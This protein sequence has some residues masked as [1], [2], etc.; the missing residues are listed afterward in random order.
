MKAL[1]LT[2]GNSPIHINHDVWFNATDMAN[3]FGKRPI[4]WLKQKETKEYIRLLCEDY[5]VRENHFL[6][7]QKGKGKN[8]TWF[9]HKLAIRFAQ[10]LDTRF[11]IWCDKQIYELLTGNWQKERD[12]SKAYYRMMTDTLQQSRIDQGKETKTHHYINEAKLI[13]YALTGTYDSIDRDN[14]DKRM[15]SGIK[16]LETLNSALIG[17]GKPREERKALL[18]EKA[19]PY[20]H[21]NLLEVAR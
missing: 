14:A 19:A 2:F 10:W 15:L 11:A 4:D 13:N 17:M 5:E 12:A 18:W 21:S 6:I 3:A 1:A 9:H 20:R 8:G 7:T 16:R